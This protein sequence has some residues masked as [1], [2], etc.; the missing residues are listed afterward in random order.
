MNLK[1]GED[2]PE[3]KVR[4]H[5]AIM[6]KYCTDKLD[7]KKKNPLIKISIIHIVYSH[8]RYNYHMYEQYDTYVAYNKN[9]NIYSRKYF[10]D[11]KSVLN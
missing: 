6:Y 3:P 8:T 1:E 7:S 4:S 2:V 9:Q 5:V 10:F 11:L